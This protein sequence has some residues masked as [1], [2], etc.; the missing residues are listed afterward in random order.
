MYVHYVVFTKY[1]EALL[2]TD[3]VLSSRSETRGGDSDMVLGL[4]FSAGSLSRCFPMKRSG[5]RS[6]LFF[7]LRVRVFLL[8][9]GEF[10]ALLL[11]LEDLLL[12]TSSTLENFVFMSRESS[13][14]VMVMTLVRWRC[15]VLFDRVT[16]FAG[17]TRVMG[18]EVV[19]SR[20]LRGRFGLT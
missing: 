18:A 16:G 14:G 5:E 9:R 1:D 2:V 6:R 8:V 13:V 20:P 4:L 19:D 10:D 7:S 11:F 17:V 3:C 12:R 15:S